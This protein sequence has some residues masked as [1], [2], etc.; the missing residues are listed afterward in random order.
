M[1]LTGVEKK[2]QPFEILADNS[3][4]PQNRVSFFHNL[5]CPPLGLGVY[6][7]HGGLVTFNQKKNDAK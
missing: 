7:Q 2:Y 4:D 3:I 6:Q 1:G 5:P